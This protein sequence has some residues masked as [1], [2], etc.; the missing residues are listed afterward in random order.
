MFEELITLKRLLQ[1]IG[2]RADWENLVYLL[3]TMSDKV[4]VY[5]CR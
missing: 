4:G 1:A 5:D 3:D 2:E